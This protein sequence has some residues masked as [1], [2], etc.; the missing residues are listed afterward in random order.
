[1][2]TITKDDVLKLYL[3]HVHPASTTR[4]KLSIQMVSQ[5][6]RPK[7]VSAAASNAF[8]ALVREAQL[9]V[10]ET[11]WKEVLGQDGLPLVT[12]F[13]NYWKQILTSKNG[14]DH[15]LD[16]IPGLVEKHPVD[17]EGKDTPRPG[18]T[19]ISDLKEF[20][21]SLKRSVDPGPM[22]QWGDL[23]ISRF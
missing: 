11:A 23:P 21:A 15:L 18:V 4:A 3:S 9:D 5:K 22:V 1:L 16:A 20:R 8:E 12:E 19:Y 17:G 6:S 7:K 13:T 2:K 14:V 10:N